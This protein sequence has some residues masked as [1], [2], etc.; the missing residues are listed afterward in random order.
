MEDSTNGAMNRY[1]NAL[2]DTVPC[3]V[4]FFEMKPE[5][6]ELTYFN[7]L[8]LALTGYAREE[9]NLLVKTDPFGFVMP[10]DAAMVQIQIEH[11]LSSKEQ[12]DLVY[13]AQ[14]KKDILWLHLIAH[15]FEW[16]KNK[17]LIIASIIDISDEIKMR[18]QLKAMIANIPGGVVTFEASDSCIMQTFLSDNFKKRIG[19]SNEFPDQHDIT[20]DFQFVHPEDLPKLQDTYADVLS[21]VNSID[22]TIRIQDKDARYFWVNLKATVYQDVG[23]KR[24][25]Y[26][27]YSDVDANVRAMTEIESSRNRLESAITSLPGG[28]G[29]FRFTR[30]FAQP[31]YFSDRLC[32][33][34][35]M[36]REQFVRSFSPNHPF[37]NLDG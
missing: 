29:L 4:L 9:F 16:G 35:G 19:Y 25:F 5:K 37:G 31:V 12:I 27:I 3:G 36:S 13:H 11:L 6:L 8:V 34:F 33:V 10:E 28:V 20:L 2:F 17:S 32:A 30:D 15:T 24:L 7:N 23:G 21:G 22:L 18:N 1:L 14:A 26:G